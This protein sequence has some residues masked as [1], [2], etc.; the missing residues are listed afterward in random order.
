[1]QMETWA[2]RSNQFCEL[3]KAQATVSRENPLAYEL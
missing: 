3:P 1:M 2:V